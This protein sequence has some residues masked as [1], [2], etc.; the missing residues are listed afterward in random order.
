MKLVVENFLSSSQTTR[1]AWVDAVHKLNSMNGV[2]TLAFQ[3][4]CLYSLL[5]LKPPAW[6]L[7]PKDTSNSVV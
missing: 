7:H 1:A 3:V 6:M 5:H 2:G 4:S